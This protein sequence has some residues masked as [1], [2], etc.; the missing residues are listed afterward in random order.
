MCTKAGRFMWV[1]GLELTRAASKFEELR[2][3]GDQH[4][5]GL[6]STTGGI[7]SHE[8]HIREEL[9]ESM[10]SAEDSHVAMVY[11]GGIMAR[12]DVRVYL[13]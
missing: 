13:V 2:L 5:R 4:H 1:R 9:V 12:E 10:S 11:R 6:R 7:R 3:Q 8:G